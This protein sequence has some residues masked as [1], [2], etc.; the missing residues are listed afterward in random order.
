MSRQKRKCFCLAVLVLFCLSMFYAV[1]AFAGSADSVIVEDGAGILTD[2]EEARLQ[3]MAQSLAGK[4]R[5]D[6][7]VVSAGSTGG[8]SAQKYAEDYYMDH[9]HQDNGLVCL[10]DMDNREL[11]VATSGDSIFY[12]TDDRISNILD[13]AYVY[14]ADGKYAESF[15]AM[16]QDISQYY[17]DGI[18]SDTYTFDMETG[19]IV[20]YTPPKKITLMEAQADLGAGILSALGLGGAV[21]SGYKR[22]GK[23]VSYSFHDNGSLALSARNDRLINRFVTTRHIPKSPP[24]SSGGGFSGGGHMST[25][26]T[27]SGG[28]TFGGGG[29][30]F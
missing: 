6:I 10:I 26:H 8:R 2:S 4:T 23:K 18:E 15:E 11:Y 20:A 9:F 5:W 25:I 22:K 13:D 28:H 27:G 19:Q 24:P 14:A 7:R 12:L 3:E 21:S 30:K 1:P 16:L 17:E 29:R